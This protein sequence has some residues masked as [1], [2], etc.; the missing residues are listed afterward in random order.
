[1]AWELLYDADAEKAL[2]KLDKAIGR[3]VVAFLDEVCQLDD[4]ASRGHPL[5]GPWAGFHRYR[6][7]QL[8][9]IVKIE[10]G[11]VELHVIQLGRR[12]SVY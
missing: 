7:G 10:R 12:D 1:M 5:S 2:A 4:P 6:V 8:R 9:I 3:K 11:R